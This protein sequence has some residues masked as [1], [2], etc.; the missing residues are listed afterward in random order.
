MDP[1]SGDTN[2]SSQTQS[3][4]VSEPGAGVV[5]D[6]GGVNTLQEPL[7][8]VLNIQLLVTLFGTVFLIL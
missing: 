5:E 2:L 4:P 8:V 7:S 3:E 6:T 1:A